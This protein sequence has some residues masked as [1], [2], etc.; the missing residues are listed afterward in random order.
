ME[1]RLDLKDELKNFLNKDSQYTIPIFIPHKGCPNDCVFCNQKKISGELRDVSVEDVDNLIKEYL[2]FFTN[3]DKRI[4]VA[5]FGGSFTGIEIE[6]QKAYLKIANKYLKMGK[7][8]SIRL[9]TRP[10]YINDDILM[11]LKEYG[12]GTIELGVQSMRNNILEEAHRGHTVLDVINASNK[13]KQY[14]IRLGH[15]IMIGLPKSTIEDEI[16]TIRE[17]LKLGPSQLRIYPVYV[18]ED[19]EL[20]A[21]YKNNVYKPLS[22]PEAV[23]R[24][25]AVIRE[26][27][28][29]N[30]SIIRL[31]LQSTGE[32]TTSNANIFGPVS[33][34]F[35]EYVMAE[36]VRDRI[37]EKI[38]SKKIKDDIIV[39]VPRKYISVAIGPKKVNKIYFEQKYSIKYIVKGEI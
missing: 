25:K 13:I 18:I 27:Q 39:Y 16:Y 15:Q 5:F 2:Q 20:Y 34:N 31:G 29:T 12:V 3:K 6:L 11:V 32:I 4:E 10:D 35:A 24:C 7:I 9:S 36:L 33:D 1:I 22:I 26:C 30:I 28:K 8:D 38:K 19:S 37:S 21:M 23:K 14:D 17:C